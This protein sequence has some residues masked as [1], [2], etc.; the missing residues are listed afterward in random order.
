VIGKLRA[1]NFRVGD[2]FEQGV[3][4]RHGEISAGLVDG[5]EW[6]THQGGVLG[7]VEADDADRMGDS[8]DNVGLRQRPNSRSVAAQLGS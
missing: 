4:S 8:D 6:H 2:A 3:E 1:G 7:V 5:S